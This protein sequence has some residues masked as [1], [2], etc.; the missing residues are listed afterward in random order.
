MANPAY[1]SI[2]P[3]A[4]P[5]AYNPEGAEKLAKAGKLEE[6]K[7]IDLKNYV[8]SKTSNPWLDYTDGKILTHHK[9]EKHL[10]F[11]NL[12]VIP[13]VVYPILSL[14]GHLYIAISRDKKAEAYEKINDY[15]DGLQALSNEWDVSKNGEKEK[16]YFVV[17][18][19]DLNVIKKILEQDSVDIETDPLY[20]QLQH[21]ELYEFQYIK[22]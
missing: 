1:Q 9:W 16:R 10:W 13:L 3:S 21:P 22:K 11:A 14:F 20:Y 7:V 17:S 4:P 18:A 12:F 5:P 15:I 6:R 19:T 2:G 8:G